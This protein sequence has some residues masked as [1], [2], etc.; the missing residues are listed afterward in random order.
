VDQRRE[1]PL[2]LDRRELLDLDAEHRS[3]GRGEIAQSV[4]ERGDAL[5]H[6]IGDNVG[7]RRQHETGSRLDS[8]EPFGKLDEELDGRGRKL[9]HVVEQHRDRP[10]DRGL[11]QQIAQRLRDGVVNGPQLRAAEN[12]TR[13]LGD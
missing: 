6:R 9:L 1:Q 12:E 7:V 4:V 11:T 10:A 2:R 8:G 3:M 5:D 13:H